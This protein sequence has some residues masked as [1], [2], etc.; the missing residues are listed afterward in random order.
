MA[1]ASAGGSRVGS[2]KSK[3]G[4]VYA[5]GSSQAKAILAARKAKK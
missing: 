2:V 1:T 5:K 3:S 4:K